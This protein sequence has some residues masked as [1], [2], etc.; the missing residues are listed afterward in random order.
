[1]YGVHREG[2]GRRAL[3][4]WQHPNSRLRSAPRRLFDFQAGVP[5]PFQG[6]VQQ[7]T[8]LGFRHWLVSLRPHAESEGR[9]CVGVASGVGHDPGAGSCSD[10]GD[11]VGPNANAKIAGAEANLCEVVGTGVF[12]CA[13]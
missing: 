5:G 10:R 1:M 12:Q 11:H 7:R 9:R 6:K 2:L 4:S 8:R 3:A 13:V